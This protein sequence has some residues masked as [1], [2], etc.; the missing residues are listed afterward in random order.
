MT[1]RTTTSPEASPTKGTDA[2]K[3]QN[4]ESEDE[5]S[6]KAPSQRFTK[7][8]KLKVTVQDE[9]SSDGKIIVNHDNDDDGEHGAGS[10]LAHLIEMR[11]ED[12][13]LVLVSRWYGG[14]HL[15]PKRF[16]H[17]VNVAR[18]HLVQCHNEGKLQ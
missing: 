15:G 1:Q 10:S 14:I 8:K 16:A 7:L 11:K 12:G 17:I 6:K 9:E 3:L 5:G 13:V 2:E 4:S 18:D